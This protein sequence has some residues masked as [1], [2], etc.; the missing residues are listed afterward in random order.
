[1]NLDEEKV[2]EKVELEIEEI[3]LNPTHDDNNNN[4][5]QTDK[6]HKNHESSFK[7]QTNPDDIVVEI[8]KDSENKIDIE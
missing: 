4:N 6:K 7:L 8:E 3:S 1:M 2:I 5:K